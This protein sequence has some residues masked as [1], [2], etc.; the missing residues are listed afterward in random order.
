MRSL[1]LYGV[2][3]LLLG[4]GLVTLVEQDPGYIYVSWRDS[5][6]ETSL[7]FGITLA[8]VV[9]MLV[10]LLLKFITKILRSRLTLM[11]W[12][13]SRKS[14]NA[15]ALSNRGLI[16]F[17]E[18]NWEQSRKQLLRAAR[19]TEAP[20][21]NHLIAARAS[22]RLGDVDEARRQLGIAETIDGDAGIAVELTQA[23]LQLTAGQYEQALATL[24]RA[25]AN[26]N[27]HP[28]VVELLARAH[29]QLEDWESLREILPEL[30][31]YKLNASGHLSDTE[32]RM[33]L[34]LMS[35]AI[36]APDA[37]GALEKLWRSVPA[38]FKSQ[39]RFRQ[40]FI[41]QLRYL[42]A[43]I[44]LE[45]RVIEFLDNEWDATLVDSLGRFTPKQPKKLL[46]TLER[47]LAQQGKEYP[48]MMA[49]ARV[50]LHAHEWDRAEA[51]LLE[52]SLQEDAAEA[53]WL[54]S[55]LYRATGRQE[56]AVKLLEQASRELHGEPEVP[57][58]ERDQG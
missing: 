1:F 55:A 40:H 18:G 25:R 53:A 5:S 57:L 21:L 45:R 27:K 30:K 42:K 22:F 26:A 39:K 50:A 19:Y 46:K 8:L 33:W 15:T 24:V 32:E 52:A 7:W 12:L 43:Y 20:L 49:A 9:W 51:F 4:A 36:E 10:A 48:L 17:V 14:R 37:E 23:E 34:G 6:I 38:E 11:D 2:L 47:W 13:G 54:L 28:Y 3:G 35:S 29:L 58:P 31:K 44:A 41:E 56:E 16:N